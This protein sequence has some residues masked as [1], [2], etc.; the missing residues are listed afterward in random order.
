MLLLLPALS[1]ALN[2]QLPHAS[3]PAV[4]SAVAVS[5][6][7]SLVLMAKKKQKGKGPKEASAALEALDAWESNAGA[8]G[9]G[10]GADNGLAPVVAK[11]G[12]KPKKEAQPEAAAASASAAAPVATLAEKVARI[13]QELGLDE[14]LP[15]G[16]AIKAAN[17]A[18]GLEPEGVMAAQVT[19]LLQQLN[20]FDME[21]SAAAAPPAAA[22][23][24]AV[25]EPKAA[26]EE[27]V[28][29]VVAEVVE[30]DEP[31]AEV[32]AKVELAPGEVKLSKKKQEAQEKAKAKKEGASEESDAK[33]AA[34][35]DTSGRRAAG[36]VRV[37]TFEGAAPGFAYVKMDGGKL[38]FRNQEVLRGVTWDVQ[39]GQRVGLVG[40]NGAGKTT[41]LRVLAGELELEEGEVIKST[42]ELRT[43][44]LRQ[45]FREEMDQDASLREEL[46]KA[47]SDVLQLQAR[48]TEAEESLAAAG[49]DVEAMQ[50]ALDSMAELQTQLD[51]SDAT[52]MERRVDKVMGAMGF[53]PTDAEL[54]VSS[55]SGGWKMRIGLAKTLLQEPQVLLLDEPTN[56]MDLE[57]VEWLE[58]YLREQTEKIAL[59]I[60]SH[61]REFL[62]RV[63]TKIVETNQGVAHSY[64]GNYRSF[65]DQKAE[66]EALQME[67]YERQQKD[68]R[69]LKNE[70]SKLG[71]IEGQAVTARQKERQ[72]KEIA[73][74]GPDHVSRPFVDKKKFSFR[75]PPA[76]R[77]GKEVIAI[78]GVTHGYGATTLFRDVDLLI[79]RG[80]RIAILGPNGAGKTTLLK[81]IMGFETPRE[82]T[83][84]VVGTNAEV[85][86][87]EQDQANALPMDN[88]V[89]Q[90]MEDA[91]RKTDIVYEQIRAL[92]GKFMFKAEK[93]DDKLSTLS[94]GEKARVALCRM[95]M[96]PSNVLVLD[97]PT[98]H[99]DIGAKEVLEEA[100]QNFEGTVLM[101]SHDRYFVSQTAN[102]ILAV[103]GD[104]VVVYDGDYK[105]YME[106]HEDTKDKVE[107]RYITGL[108]KIRAAPVI[109]FQPAE[110]KQKKKKSFGGKGGPSGNKNKGVKNAKRATSLN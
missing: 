94:G 36:T 41:Q 46:T 10:D 72:L 24:A 100:I 82:G 102:T 83:A 90:T 53:A 99:L 17:E 74:G 56:H 3:S 65:L 39:T 88:T 43:S 97:E 107:G 49:D 28:A 7:S 50:V 62:D 20:V 110:E 13:K 1:P 70:I 22:P 57:S 84:G 60:V 69:A 9:G 12:K 19:N 67:R 47:F 4:R 91:G 5:R 6:T 25:P 31:V 44:F 29:E 78:E 80:D 14:A 96:T 98:N 87:F 8:P 11:K 81:L 16:P 23:P 34:G 64:N 95:M 58:N 35:R 109:E 55:F 108:Q 38:R 75:F 105:A 37:E 79:E 27:V 61:D 48:Y 85:H 104:K 21:G 30:V 103:E 26:A 18:M 15:L 73:E 33:A 77:S 66:L 42:S 63:C 101:V 86:F 92:L 89:L 40:S 71:A 59:V 76:P 106:E 51:N 68:I 52:A 32:V 54:P 2:F 45:E 93:V